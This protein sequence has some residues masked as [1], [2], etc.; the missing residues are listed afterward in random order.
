MLIAC[1]NLANLSLTRT[2]GRLR[3]AA[4]RTALGA[5]RERLVRRVVLEQLLLAAAGG[6]LGLLVAWEAID[7]FVW[8]APIDLPRVQRREPSTPG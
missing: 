6:A 8:T 4:V 7:L 1:S 3:D 5:S 2:F